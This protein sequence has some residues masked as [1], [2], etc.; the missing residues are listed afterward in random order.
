MLF[1]KVAKAGVTKYLVCPQTWSRGDSKCLADLVRVDTLTCGYR[2]E[3]LME[4]K[5]AYSGAFE[6]LLEN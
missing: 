3:C 4:L 6:H 2:V 5:S 1:F